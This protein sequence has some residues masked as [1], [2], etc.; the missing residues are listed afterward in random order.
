MIVVTSCNGSSPNGLMRFGDVESAVKRQ[1]STTTSDDPS[2]NYD[3]LDLEIDHGCCQ[4]P[5][6]QRH[7]QLYKYQ[8]V[9]NFLKSNPYVLNGYRSLLPF[10]LCCKR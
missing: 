9:P 2:G 3:I 8:E 4:G 5:S 1:V 10:S 6:S 7:I